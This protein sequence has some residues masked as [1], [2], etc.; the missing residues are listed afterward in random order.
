MAAAGESGGPFALGVAQPSAGSYRKAAVRSGAPDVSNAGETVRS[1]KTVARA[2]R[3]VT[4]IRYSRLR[5]RSNIA[6]WSVSSVRPSQKSLWASC[7][8]HV[9]TC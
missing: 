4:F 2:P 5:P 1:R 7:F 6:A 3:A 8:L 9:L